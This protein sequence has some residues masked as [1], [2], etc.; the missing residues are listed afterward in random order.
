MESVVLFYYFSQPLVNDTGCD[1]PQE[2]HQPDALEVLEI[3]LGDQHDTL[4]DTCLFQVIFMK[5]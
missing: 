5:R 2:I 4:K 1:L 3:P